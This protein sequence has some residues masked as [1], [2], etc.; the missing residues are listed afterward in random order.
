MRRRLRRSSCNA[1]QQVRGSDGADIYN[2]PLVIIISR[3]IENMTCLNVGG[4]RSSE[5]G[6]LIPLEQQLAQLF[7]YRIGRCRADR[8]RCIVRRRELNVSRILV[9]RRDAE[10]L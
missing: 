5:E 10:S 7:V 9:R 2:M 1:T 3:A 8:R 4:W 6:R